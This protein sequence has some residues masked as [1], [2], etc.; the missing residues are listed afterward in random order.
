MR[1]HERAQPPGPHCALVIGGVALLLAAQVPPLVS[2]IGGSEA[3]QPV[4]GKQVE[5]TGVNHGA[6][7]GRLERACGER[8]GE[9]L[10]RPQRRIVSFG[11]VD[12]VKATIRCRIPKT[13]EARARLRRQ[14][15]VAGCRLSDDASKLHQARECVVPQRVHLDRLAD[16]RRNDALAH[17]GVHPG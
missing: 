13:P 12:N 7:L 6:L 11:T 2:R 1:D 3:A 10:I 4:T 9:Q 16:S 17:L 8:N 5:R 14:T 15:F